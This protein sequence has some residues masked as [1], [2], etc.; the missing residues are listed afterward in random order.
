MESWQ[1]QLGRWVREGC[2]V[3]PPGCARVADVQV[4][5]AVAAGV[6]L[7]A[8]GVVVI[9]AA[10]EGDAERLAGELR[11]LQ[12]MV[13]DRRPA[14]V[15][16]AIRG[17]RREW[18][19]ENE[20]ARCAAL[21]AA[22]TGEPGIFLTSVA[23]LLGTTTDPALFRRVSFALSVGQGNVAP[24]ELARR[25]A[26]LDYDNEA[27]VTMPG[28][29]S[30]RGG[31]LDVYSPLYEAPVRI[32]FFGN[33]IDTLRFFDPESQRS[34]KPLD[35]V[36]IVP[37]GEAALPSAAGGTATLL[38]YVPASAP[39]L[40]VEPLDIAAHLAE[41]A[42][43]GEAARWE[44]VRSSQ[45][46]RT[47]EI[48]AHWVDRSADEG[49]DDVPSAAIP[50]TGIARGALPLLSELGAE[51]AILHWQ[52]LRDL[53]VRWCTNGHTVVAC[54]GNPGEAAR[55]EEMRRGDERTRALPL[56]VTP[57]R[58]GAGL[59]LPTAGLV[60]LSE[61]DLFGK[62]QATERPAAT[63]YRGDHAEH[64]ELALEEGVL[65]VHLTHGISLYHGIRQI[66]V[67]GVLQECM[68]LEFDD[69]DRIFVPLDQA[70]LVSR[71][72][73]GTK[74][75]PKLSKVGGT[76]WKNAR[77]AASGAALDLAAD[78]L[79]LEAMRKAAA[80]M[81]QRIV[82]DWEEDFA[83]AFPYVET[84]DQTAAIADVLADMARPQPMDRLLCGDV[85]YG[86]TEVAMR[87]AFRT[88][89]NGGQVGVLVPTTL[90]AEQH[91]QTFR[92]RM[93]EYPVSIEML[94]RFRTDAEQAAIL[95]RLA[96]GRIDI[97]IGTH[98]LVQSDVAFANLRLLII[99][100]EQRFG[101]RDKERLKRLRASVDILALTATPIPR[102]LYLSLSGIRNLSTI[103][104]PPAERLPVKTI[105]AQY[106]PA[107]I[108]E[109]VR[110]ELERHGQVFYLHNRVRTIDAACRELAAAVPEA[111]FAVAHGQMPAHE[112][113]AVML[114]YLSRQIDVL[115]CT[116]II[117]S[118]LD[119]PNANTI[120]IDRADAL[121]LAELYQLR[122]RVGRYHHQAYAYL[123][124]PPMGALP[125]N[126]RE[127]IAAIR[128]YTHL[129]AGFKLALRDLEIRGAGNLL[130]AEQSGHIAA[131]GFELYCTLLREAV[132]R[133]D[134]RAE[135]PRA[136]VPVSL[137][138]LRYGFAGGDERQAAG[139]PPVYIVE[140][141]LRIEFYKRIQ[142]VRSL[143]DVESLATEL[144]DRF[145]PW[146]AP[147]ERL[148]QV[149]RIR[150]LATATGIE[151][152][153]VRGRRVL[154]RTGEG[155]VKTVEGRLP[156][157]TTDDAFEQPAQLVRLLA[158]YAKTGHI[159]QTRIG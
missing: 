83:N 118:G 122:G 23:G 137:D 82:G 43:P 15:V 113:E 99:D 127:R 5:P 107:I 116:T 119:I 42:E 121:G 3:H 109:A 76:Q 60:L 21:D 8:D 24:D 91:F 27:Q 33:T 125:R 38:D 126:A 147:V 62:R 1:E 103:M 10:E 90:L 36:R 44:R 32:E 146:P 102:T 97:V 153:A 46:P 74:K 138:G 40:V 81:E 48:T 31:I 9:V 158:A 52:L 114:R 104:T 159:R 55:L 45:R 22:L 123:L 117:E 70:H 65:A 151:D 68:E 111:R 30:R 20:A 57:L 141:G 66:D 35:A 96:L 49:G 134:Q 54:C 115:V 2:A 94:S 51:G 25:L 140:E 142:G 80:G 88:V 4:T 13:G 58:L 130:G 12:A 101:V 39:L 79:R 18:V 120:I 41:F 59:V 105:V 64:E 157:L 129:G 87:A 61:H 86:K 63:P 128:Q 139:I 155:F 92:D 136:P 56:T 156:E 19:I 26:D 34:F 71:Y 28:E 106:D 93:A 14:R 133:L 78:L 7:A 53:L 148:L 95:E 149:A 6:A 72:M 144:R 29:F 11:N 67:G 75:L 17:L 131:V 89:M 69:D 143:K 150:A 73:G 145:G 112:L 98:R 124:L 152:V 110:R 37:R 85:G 100:E 50:C 77:E 47:V 16:P 154:L 135:A 108:R 132:A 84:T